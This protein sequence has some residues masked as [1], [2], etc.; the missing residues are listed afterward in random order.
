MPIPAPNLDNRR[1]QDIVDEA[2]RLIPQYCPEWTD[3]NVSDPGIALLELFA[4]MTESL[5]YRSN[6]LTEKIYIR[7]LELLGTRLDPPSSARAPLTFYLSAPQ[8]GEITIPKGTEAATLRTETIPA[9]VFTT[10]ADLPIRPPLISGVFTHRSSHG[11]EDG[12]V[13]HELNRLVREQSIVMFPDPPSI[14]D[15]FLVAFEKDLS[16]HVLALVLGCETH[17]G[18][19]VDPSDPPLIWEVWQGDLARWVACSLQEDTTGGFNHDGEIV[20]RLPTMMQGDFAGTDAYWLRCRLTERDGR[21]YEVSPELQ[22]HFRVESRGGTVPARHAIAVSNEV[23]GKSDGTPGQRFT[24]LNAP[25]LARDAETDHLV[26]DPPD[27]PPQVWR[28]VEDFGEAGADDRCY[29]LD[30]VD[31]TLTLGPA[32]LQPDGNMYHFGAIPTK[33]SILHF[34]RYMFGGGVVGNVPAGNIS[35]LKS[36]MTYIAEVTNHEPALGGRDAQT[37]EDAKVRA[38]HRLR[39]SARAV[40]AGDFEFH[41]MQVPGV[42]RARC[43]AP[44]EQ[45]GEVGAIRPGHVFVIVLPQV[46][47]PDRPQPEQLALSP[48]FRTSILDHLHSRCVLGVGVEVRPPEFV[49]ISVKAELRVPIDSHPVVRREVQRR[50]EAELYEFLNPFKG[51]THRKGWPFGRDLYLTEVYGLLQRIPNVEFIDNVRLEIVDPGKTASRPA[52]P[53]V[54]VGPH[55]LVCS[56][57]HQITVTQADE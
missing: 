49:W 23:L 4:W 22:R 32:L 51:G 35:I 43:L 29:T 14:G 34:S 53:R 10:E 30:S 5:L 3:H 45:P 27:S 39:S 1:F 12:W 17:G 42:A 57:Q 9:I 7:F 36:S 37:V 33:G 44:G 31:G 56:A 52:P 54:E 21:R 50:A 11:D 26:V 24:L 18:A 41:T 48:A 47:A 28:E 20:L 8:A 55:A 40:T 16:H 13:R 25:L 2:K 38:G 15:E 19:G 46:L 6:Q